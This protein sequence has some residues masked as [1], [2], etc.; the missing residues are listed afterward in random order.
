MAYQLDPENGPMNAC[1]SYEQ[2]NAYR[3]ISLQVSV[4]E[5]VSVWV[6]VTVSVD[7]R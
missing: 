5:S 2:S 4:C 1:L 6:N 3:V 7:K